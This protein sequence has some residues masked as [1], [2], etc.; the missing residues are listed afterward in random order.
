MFFKKVYDNL[1]KVPY[2][3]TISYKELAQKSGNERAYRAVGNA[4]KY[5]PLPL[6]IP[7]HR[8]IKANGEIG[9]FAGGKNLKK[10]LLSLENNIY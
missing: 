8:V 1:I 3:N 10:I 6:V 7:C 2:G 4:C 5:N 9:D